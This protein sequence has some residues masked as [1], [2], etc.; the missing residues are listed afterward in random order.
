MCKANSNCEG[1]ISSANN[2]VS[3]HA[4]NHT[5]KDASKDADNSSTTHYLSAEW[6][7]KGQRAQPG[8]EKCVHAH[9]VSDQ[10]ADLG[11]CQE[12]SNHTDKDASKDADNS[13]TT[14][15]L[16]AECVTIAKV[17]L[18]SP[19]A[20]DRWLAR[21][22]QEQCWA[23]LR[24]VAGFSSSMCNTLTRMPARMLTTVQLHTISVLNV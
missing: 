11:P 24:A 5:D 7:R 3:N 17:I 23:I 14:H 12:V 18:L 4:D 9:Q 2:H 16:S 19:C 21:S 15:Y 6:H 8:Q 22:S 13:S 20:F 10:I 1:T